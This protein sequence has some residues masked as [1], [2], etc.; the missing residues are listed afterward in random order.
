MISL[1]LNNNPIMK[2]A[3]RLSFFLLAMIFLSLTSCTKTDTNSGS[4]NDRDK[5]L[6]TYSVHEIH[7]KSDFEVT[8]KA[9]PNESSRVLIDNFA[10]LLPGNQATAYISGNS[11]TLDANQSVGNMTN[12]SGS[13]LMSGTTKITWSYTMTDGATRIDATATYTKK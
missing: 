6:G 7:T 11:I 3:A 5:F 1:N 12:I 2:R 9:D 13:G 8:I 4:S 10:N